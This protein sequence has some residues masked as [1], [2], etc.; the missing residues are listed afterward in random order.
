MKIRNFREQIVQDVD[1]DYIIDYL[2]S[3]EVI[4]EDEYQLIKHEVSIFHNLQ[5]KNKNNNNLREKILAWTRN[6]T[7]VSSFMR[8]RYNH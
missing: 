5:E 8:W 6:R 2:I 3:R 7:R 4:S 1:T